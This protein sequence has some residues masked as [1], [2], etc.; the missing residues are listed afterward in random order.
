VRRRVLL[1]ILGLTTVSILL[2]GVPL[3][4]VFERLQNE[5]ASLRLEREAFAASHSVPGDFAANPDLIEFPQSSDG[6]VFGLYDRSGS[7]VAGVGPPTAD[8]ATMRALQDEIADVETPELRVA[9]VPISADEAVVGALR[10]AQSNVAGEART[11]WILA[12]IGLLGA[13]VIVVGAVVGYVVAGRLTRPVLRLRDAAVR[14]GEG[15]FTVEVP[16]SRVSE[17]DEA[18]KAMTAT[19]R[20]LDDLLERERMF[21]SDVS[22]QLR[23]PVA[24]LRTAIET[25]LQFPRE[26]SSEVLREALVDLDRLEKTIDDLLAIAR[27]ADGG[28]TTLALVDVLDEVRAK[29]GKQ[30]AMDSRGLSIVPVQSAPR[31]NASRSMLVQA[32]DVLLD[33]AL[34]HGEGDV[35]MKLDVGEESVTIS[36]SDEGPGFVSL[37]NPESI[38]SRDT[39]TSSGLGLPLARRL[40]ETMGGRLSLGRPG[41]RPRIEIVLQR[42]DR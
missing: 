34:L 23:T 11:A 4:F 9:A 37:A 32:I 13:L 36:I 14:L 21:S 18:A 2:F 33:N 42:A 27:K 1:A 6:V 22:H 17:I 20:R 10:A 38:F 30:F 31:V 41:P 5:D 7:L 19:A 29:W 40:V 3:A 25:E 12:T 26:D 28:Q 24:G 39:E 15:D 16:G 35:D 8:D